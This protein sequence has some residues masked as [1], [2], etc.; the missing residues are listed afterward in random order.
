[1][2][3]FF[4][5]YNFD[6]GAKCVIF[7]H[8]APSIYTSFMCFNLVVVFKVLYFST[9]TMWCVALKDWYN[10]FFVLSNNNK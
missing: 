5:Y 10:Y 2:Q 8:F 3:G 6:T 7:I 9:L 1:M 4:V